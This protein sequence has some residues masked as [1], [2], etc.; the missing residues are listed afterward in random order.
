MKHLSMLMAMFLIVGCQTTQS[1]ETETKPE[2]VKEV[3]VLPTEKEVPAPKQELTENP[4]QSVD[5]PAN[6]VV[7]STKPVMCGRIDTVLSR[8]E[9]SF[10]EKPVMVGKAPSINGK[11]VMVTLT[12]NE[13][14]GSYTFLEQMPMENR[15]ICIIS[16]GNGELTFKMLGSSY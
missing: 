12:Y 7:T 1:A 15:L 4:F 14:T 16:S 11:Q 5:I 6:Q 8:M 13:K 3:K 10:G 2:V 9:S